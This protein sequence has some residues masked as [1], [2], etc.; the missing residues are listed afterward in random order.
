MKSSNPVLRG[1]TFSTFA[2]GEDRMSTNGVIT[3]SLI[4]FLLL[5]A[6]FAYTWDMASG[7]TPQNAAALAGLGGISGMI[8]SIVISFK[9]QWAPFLAPVFAVAEG[10]M[11]GAISAWYENGQAIGGY[12]GIVQQAA[13]ATLGTFVTMLV[14]YRAG[15]IKVTDRFRAIVT[16][17]MFSI[18]IVYMAA[19]IMSMFGASMPF[20]NDAS[21]IGIGISILVIGVASMMLLVDFDIIERGVAQ[22]APKYMEWYG[23]FAL[24]VTLVWIYVEFLRLLSKLNRR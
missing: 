17:A 6:A 7:S 23:G 16:T 11:L 18:F 13:M 3:K 20:L 4:L 24:M 15:I 5:G 19:W 10:L 9:M 22:G 21:P 14:I 8:L 1:G 2:A 12:E